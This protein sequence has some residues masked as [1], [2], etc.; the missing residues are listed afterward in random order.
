MPWKGSLICTTFYMPSRFFPLFMVVTASWN[1]L[2]PHQKQCHHTDFFNCKYY[3]CPLPHKQHRLR[4]RFF[5]SQWG[6]LGM[7]GWHSVKCQGLSTWSGCLG[8]Q[9]FCWL[10]DTLVAFL[11][12]SSTSPSTSSVSLD[13]LLLPLCFDHSSSLIWAPHVEIGVLGKCLALVPQFLHLL[14]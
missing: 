2:H 7:S 4:K 8:L 13:T 1:F 12:Q 9:L 10:Y 3:W 6:H 5:C 11:S 14:V